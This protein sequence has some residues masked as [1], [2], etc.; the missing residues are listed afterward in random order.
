M[1]WLQNNIGGTVRAKTGRKPG[2]KPTYDW[3]IYSE[4]AARILQAILPYL[5]VKRKHAAIALELRQLQVGWNRRIPLSQAE[6][7]A[8]EALRQQ[9]LALNA[10]GVT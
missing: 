5:I 7:A 1:A 10:K 2:W 4:N 3:T 8:R 6:V 9:L